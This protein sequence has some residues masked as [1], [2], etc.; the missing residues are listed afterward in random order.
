M[1]QGRARTMSAAPDDVWPEPAVGFD[2]VNLDRTERRFSTISGALL[3][4]GG[5]H[6]RSLPMI[7]G[8]GALLYRG[9][10]GYCPVYR[11]FERLSGMPLTDGLQ[12]EASIAVHKPVEQVYALWRHLENLPRFMSHLESVTPTYDNRSHWVA[13]MPAPLRLEWDAEISDDQQNKKISWCSLPQSSVH[14]AGSVFFHALPERGSTE[15]KIIF[16]YRP[17]AGSAGTAAAKLLN[18]LTQNQI[19]ADLRAFKAV[20]ETGERPTTAG[21]PSGRAVRH[22]GAT[23]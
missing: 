15:I 6:R 8:G 11:S 5:L 10:S 14:H 2:D 17:P 19:K 20:A 1:Y 22:S 13:H 9:V 16:G 3:F 7:L 21:Q 23:A 18:V 4:L 12:F